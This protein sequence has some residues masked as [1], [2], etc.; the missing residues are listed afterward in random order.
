LQQAEKRLKQA[1]EE[2]A[3]RKKE[4]KEAKETKATRVR[5]AR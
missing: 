1:R 5:D 2:D 4:A 3:R